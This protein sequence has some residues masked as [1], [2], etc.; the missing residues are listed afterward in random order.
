MSGN[1]HKCPVSDDEIL[2]EPDLTDAQRVA[3]DLLVSGASDVAVAKALNVVPKTL[4]RWKK[5]NPHFRNAL[6]GRR[7][8]L[9]DQ[10]SDR[11][12]AMLNKSL[13]IL[14]RQMNDTWNPTSFR[15]AKSLLTLAQLAKY[16]KPPDEPA[17]V[18]E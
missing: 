9:L 15:A 12:R 5:H 17:P 10:S 3:I 11:F 18:P 8:D 13:D 16:L 2:P 6:R 7:E 1:V 4:Y 14:E